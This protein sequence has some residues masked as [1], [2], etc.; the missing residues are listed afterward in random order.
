[1]FAKKGISLALG[2]GGAR[3]LAHIGALRVLEN[4]GIPI[5]QLVGT[6]MGAIVG[7]A[8]AQLGKIDAVE[9]KFRVLM[10]SGEYKANGMLYTGINKVA[11]GWF[12]HIAS[13]IREQIVINIANFKESVFPSKRLYKILEMVLQDEK[14][15]HTKIPFAAVATDIYQG[16]EL[17]ID[18]GPIIEAVVASASLPGYFPPVKIGNRIL[19]DGA[20]TFAVPI[21]PAKTR[22]PH[23]KVV[24]IDVSD[25]LPAN[26]VLENS[27]DIV[28]HSYKITS[29]LYHDSQIKNANVLI[30]P[31]VGHYHWSEFDKIDYFIQEGEKATLAKLN[32]IIK[33]TRRLFF[34]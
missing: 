26:P 4:E 5:S 22:M 6:S 17:I 27:I 24:A 23:N 8:Y 20:F 30:E 33:L 16:K 7:A 15:E 3:G 14:I 11:S 19:I 18:Q 25:T 28:L 32:D 2:G 1:M 13:H 21:E 12:E 10:E 29:R 34:M 9:N 31:N